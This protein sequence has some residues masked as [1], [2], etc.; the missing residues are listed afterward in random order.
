MKRVEQLLVGLEVDLVGDHLL[1][2]VKKFFHREGVS[3]PA[4]EEGECW[5]LVGHLL[6]AGD[7]LNDGG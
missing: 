5:N 1:G 7:L 4:V 6:L 2:L 3:S